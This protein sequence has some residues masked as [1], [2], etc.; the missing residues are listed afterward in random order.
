MNIISTL[1]GLQLIIIMISSSVNL[2]VLS[3]GSLTVL[4]GTK[5]SHTLGISSGRRF[6]STVST[7]QPCYK[8]KQI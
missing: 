8:G 2:F 1:I 5:L 4:F 3:H 6:L 7:I